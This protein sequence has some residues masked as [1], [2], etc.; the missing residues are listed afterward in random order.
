MGSGF[1]ERRIT[2][3]R[4]V[5]ETNTLH[6]PQRPAQ[7]PT[8]ADCPHSSEAESGAENFPQHGGL[9]EQPPN[10]A[11]SQRFASVFEMKTLNWNNNHKLCSLLASKNASLKLIKI[12]IVPL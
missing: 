4:S 2:S 9:P 8:T 11:H 7:H 3:H 6:C 12:D 5:S 10:G 1:F